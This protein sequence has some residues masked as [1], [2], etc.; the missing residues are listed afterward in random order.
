[1]GTGWRR[2]F[3]TS[4]RRDPQAA[5]TGTEKRP[6]SP[7]PSPRSC[8]KLSFFS[9]GGVGSKPSTPSSQGAPPVLRCRTKSATPTPPDSPR[10]QCDA[11][12]A[13][14]VEADAVPS[15]RTPPASSNP[16]KG[17]VSALFQASST[18]SSPRSP[19]RFAL[20]K[21]SLLLS[22]QSR[23]G[24]CQ[25][26]V[27]S[28][29]G[30]TAVFTAECSHAFHFPC[31]SAHVRAQAHAHAHGGAALTCPACSAAWRQAPLLASLANAQQERKAPEEAAAS[32]EENRE[33]RPK[34]PKRRSSGRDDAAA[35]AAAEN[36]NHHPPNCKAYDDDEPLL[37]CK[38]SMSQGVQFNP[39]PEADEDDEIVDDR[40]DVTAGADDFA[41]VFANPR[42]G[43]GVGGVAASAVQ[44]A[45]LVSSG[46]RHGNYVV[47]IKVRAPPVRLDA[48]RRAPIDLVTVLDVGQGMTG[49]KLQM[50]KRA[51]RLVVASLGPA[52]R[53]AIVAFSSGFAKRLLPLRR[54]SRQGQRSHGFS[55]VGDA[56]RKAT[57]VLEDRRQR[58]P[59]ATIMLLSDTQ[60][61]QQQQ[62]DAP[63][64]SKGHQPTPRF[65]QS[66]A[67]N[68]RFAHLEIPIP[69][70]DAPAPRS[71]LKPKVAEGQFPAG[72]RLEDAFAKCVG[73]LVSVVMQDVHLQLTFP[74]GEISAVYSCGAGQRAAVLGGGRGAAAV[75]RLGDLYAEE[76][77][78]LLLELRAPLIH[79]SQHHGAHY[80]SLKCTYR[81]PASSESVC[82]AEQ[83]LLLPPL[84]TRSSSTRL[85]N[86]FVASR[87]LAESRR[88]AELSD[89]AT[90]LHLISSARSLLLQS[91]PPAPGDQDLLGALEAEA[92]ELQCRRSQQQQQQQQQNFQQ[93]SISPSLRSRRREVAASATPASV[94]A[95]GGEQLTPTSAWRAAEQLAKVA[96]MRKSL[97]R[98]SDLHGF[99]NARF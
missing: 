10:T 63:Q 6:Q 24:I 83:P 16:K 5:A 62:Q 37:L 95:G 35:A 90:A 99:E 56:L 31:I 19:S 25:Q 29:H 57:K 15:S 17:P 65:A 74:S 76:E 97:N 88:L 73:G 32:D 85:H 84:H 14:A 1:M 54:M 77:R 61:Q 60:Q 49:E 66:S 79:P 7:G 92:A 11:T 68:T 28:G 86:L 58:N 98:V 93:Q 50:L 27:R 34:P 70:G 38:A 82:G 94:G 80:L 23:C 21:A 69:I 33:N 64:P 36:R 26:S 45:A 12:A 41:A 22:R 40:M 81:D 72:P 96:I 78:E 44:E 2:A 18:P 39:I 53:L 91:S 8:A 3:C 4:I 46:R 89:S 47:A 48:A 51:M 43:S 30:S 20:F 13:A 42:R 67:A 75:V 71:P 59:V 87:A 9:G 52:D 55:C